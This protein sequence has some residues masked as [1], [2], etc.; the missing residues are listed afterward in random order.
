[1]DLVLHCLRYPGALYPLDGDH[2]T[3]TPCSSACLYDGLDEGHDIA[4]LR[5]R[6]L[7]SH[8]VREVTKLPN[9]I[10]EL[11]FLFDDRRDDSKLFLQGVVTYFSFIINVFGAM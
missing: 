9:T 10:R 6:P 5:K 11:V 2:P 4:R 7:H 3:L 1:M 8:Q